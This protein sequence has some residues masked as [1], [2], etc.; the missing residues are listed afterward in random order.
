MNMSEIKTGIEAPKDI[1]ICGEEISFR[2]E[3]KEKIIF[4]KFGKERTTNKLHIL[5]V[6]DYDG[7]GKILYEYLSWCGHNVKVV[8]N[9]AEAIG[10]TMNEDFDLVLVDLIMPN[11]TG[12]DV[13]KS[14]NGLDKKPKTGLITGWCEKFDSVEG[15]GLSVDFVVEKPFDLLTIARYIN[16]IFGVGEFQK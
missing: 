9:G 6:D 8:D 14:L 15:E 2:K 12:Y 1:V 13:I 3:T 5:V 7:V 16:D 4:S 11:V 10:I